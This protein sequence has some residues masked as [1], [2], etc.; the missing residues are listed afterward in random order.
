[1][2]GLLKRSIRLLLERI[3][4]NRRRILSCSNRIL[5]IASGQGIALFELSSLKCLDLQS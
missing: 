1:M 2:L 4:P 5:F 3:G